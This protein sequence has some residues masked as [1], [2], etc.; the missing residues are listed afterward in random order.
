MLE[1]DFKHPDYP[2]VF[3]ERVERLNHIRSHP[4]ELSALKLYYKDHIPQFITDWGCTFDP[5]NVEANLPA[6]IPFI[7]FPRQ[8]DWVEWV[9][10]SWRNRRPGVTPKSREIGVSWLAV[11]LGC[12]LGLFYDDMVIGYGSRL[13]KYVDEVGA[14]KS[15]FWKARKFIGLLPPEFRNGFDEKYDA[16]KMRIMMRKTNSILTGEAGDGIG[17]GDRTGIY[18]VDEAAHLEHPEEVDAALSQ[19]TNCRID[20]STAYGLN[21]PFHRKVTTWPKERVFRIHWRDDPRKDDAWYAKQIDELDP[22]TVAQEIDID[23]AASVEGVLIPSAWVQSAWG[24]AEVLGIVPTGA[25][26]GALDVADEGKDSLA[27]VGATGIEVDVIEEWSG[28]GLDIFASVAKSFGLCDEHGYKNFRYDAD[29]L[30][31]GVRGDAR[32]LNEKRDSSQRIKVE[33]FRGSDGVVDPKKEDTKGRKNEDY[34]KNAKAQSAW[35]LRTLFKNTH[36]AITEFRE[37]GTKDFDPDELISLSTKLDPAIKS[38][39]ELELSQPTYGLDTAGKI[40]VNKTPDG[41]R[42]PNLYDGVMIRF[43]RTKPQMTVSSDVVK[44]SAARVVPRS[45]GLRGG[46]QNRRLGMR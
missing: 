10:D 19:T 33:P 44:K 28:K 29:G 15:L 8:V 22:I 14:P 4:E 6:I 36:R 37:K 38:K 7:L 41:T 31:A 34:F 5:R 18:F 26:F 16:P 39:L 2:T 24:A 25:K 40:I 42:S 30:G 3:R 21:S 9:L 20:M 35:H 43:A 27:F 23:F 13:E 11:A 1:F 12:S 45:G 46:M 17:R 32:V